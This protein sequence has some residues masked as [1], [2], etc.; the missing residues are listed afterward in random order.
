MGED[1]MLKGCVP[2]PDEFVRLY[3]EKGYWEDIP[4]SDH[5]DEW[6]T[7]YADRPAIAFQG[8]E[9]TYRQIVQSEL[10]EAISTGQRAYNLHYTSTKI[11][12]DFCFFVLFTLTFTLYEYF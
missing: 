6:V 9:V 7:N 11:K 8:H 3:K 5:I 2:W 4:F 10:Y 12:L 1:N